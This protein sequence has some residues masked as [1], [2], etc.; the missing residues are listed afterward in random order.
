MLFTRSTTA[1]KVV[2]ALPPTPVL[3]PPSLYA[4]VVA[5]AGMSTIVVVCWAAVRQANVRGPM[6]S[7]TLY[8]FPRRSSKYAASSWAAVRFE[9][10]STTYLM[11]ALR[12]VALR[13]VP[14]VESP[15]MPV[16]GEAVTA[17]N[18]PLAGAVWPASTN[19]VTGFQS[20][21]NPDN[22][23]TPALV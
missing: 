11:L 5:S 3:L 12:T 17:G 13:T 7:L 6:P 4:F 14:S 18:V 2:L 19:S 21:R 16:Q 8:P 22:T 15:G 1:P 23:R 9:V 20:D 10:T